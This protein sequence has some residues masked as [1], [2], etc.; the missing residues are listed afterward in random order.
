MTI[1]HTPRTRNQLLLGLAGW[2]ALCYL[3]AAAGALASANAQSFYGVL[4]QPDWS[5][6]AWLFG[7]AW[8][9]LFTMMGF[10]ACLVWRAPAE[11]SARRWALGL[12]V[13]QLAANAL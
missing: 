11:P 9:L 10:A 8:T 2:M 5:P 4:V 13:L 7:P 1:Q 3:T 12:F 6:P